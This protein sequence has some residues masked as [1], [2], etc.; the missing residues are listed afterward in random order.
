MGE[1]QSTAVIA[2]G[3]FDGVHTGHRMLLEKAKELA[4]LYRAKSMVY[5]FQNHPR[6]V[7]ATAPKLLMS[8]AEKESCILRLGVDK[9]QQEVFTREMADLSPESYVGRLLFTHTVRAMV[10]GFNYSFGKGGIGAPDTLKR[11]GEERGFEVAVIPPVEFQGISVSSTRI[12]EAIELGDVALA[13]KM[14]A[15]PYTLHGKVIENRHIGRSIGF[16]TA[17]IRPEQEKVLPLCGVYATRVWLN[18]KC[19]GGVT[20]VGDNPTVG[21]NSLT[22]ETHLLEFEGNAYGETIAVKFHEF[23][24]E[25]RRF[26]DKEALAAQIRRDKAQAAAMIQGLQ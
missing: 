8:A 6:S 20:N 10:V 1:K 21:G 11:I 4:R 23:I 15:E 22:I 5:T 17:N 12:R 26:Q 19:Y 13:N 3:M 25:E 16:P 2:L 14:L 24:R 7:F 18:G 9:V